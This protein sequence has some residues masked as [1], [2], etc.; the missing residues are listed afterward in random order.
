VLRLAKKYTGQRLEAA[1]QKA[2]QTHRVNYQILSN[3]LKNNMD[4]IETSTQAKIFKIE[5]HENIRGASY[6]Q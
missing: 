3:I 4:K 5:D 1:S 6:Y 2:R